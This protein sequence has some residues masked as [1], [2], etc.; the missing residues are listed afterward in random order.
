MVQLNGSGRDRVTIALRPTSHTYTAAAGEPVRYLERKVAIE[1]DWLRMPVSGVSWEDVVAYAAWLDRT[2]RLPGAR[3]CDEREWERAARGADGRLFPHG[4]RLAPTDADFAETYGRVT[5]AFGPDEVATH[6]ASDSP[7]DVSD[8]AGNAWEW[9]SAR[10]GDGD[11]AIRGG[12]WY[13]NPLA[14]R[15]NN[16]EPTEPELREITLGLRVCASVPDGGSG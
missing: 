2:G 8:L 12:S 4:D 15:S 16:R 3:A 10:N 6:P 5:E 11:V 9:V 7:F 13:A 1:Q 14:A